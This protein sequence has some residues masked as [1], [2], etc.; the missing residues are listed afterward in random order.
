MASSLHVRKSQC[1]GT[2]IRGS[3]AQK[4]TH[5]HLTQHGRA[6]KKSDITGI[7]P[8]PSSNNSTGSAP[9]TE[10]HT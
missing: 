7:Q 5:M 10:R 9:G 2:A 4:V 8:N 3:Y 6:Y 1:T